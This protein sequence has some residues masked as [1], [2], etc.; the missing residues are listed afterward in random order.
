MA[1]QEQQFEERTTDIFNIYTNEETIEDERFGQITIMRAVKPENIAYEQIFKVERIIH[2]AGELAL[3]EQQVITRLSLENEN[4][5]EMMDYCY[6]LVDAE[7]EKY[8]FTGFYEYPNQDLQREILYRSRTFKNF[9]DLEI[10]NIVK[11]ICS[12][13]FYLQIN[14]LLHGDLR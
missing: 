14:K 3:C 7:D 4:I 6:S 10:F 8:H 12:G 9:T 1:E 11:D 13:L 5:I 2:G